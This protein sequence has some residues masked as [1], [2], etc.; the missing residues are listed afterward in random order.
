MLERLEYFKLAPTRILDAGSGPAR[1][2]RPLAARYR[3]EGIVAAD[4][5]LGML[6]SRS[7]GWLRRN[8]ADALCAKLEQLPLAA[9]TFDLVWSNMA[10]HA[11]AEPLEALKEFHRI[12]KPEGLL[13]FSML[14]PDSLKELRA[15]AGAA[16]V[17]AFH[18]M[19]DIGDMLVA[20]GFSAPVMD[21]ELLHFTYPDPSAL[22]DDLRASGQTNVRRDRPRGLAGKRFVRRLREA[23]EPRATFEIVYGHAWK[24]R[25]RAEREETV[26]TIGI[27]KRIP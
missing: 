16:R 4:F 27:F 23:L 7:R 19:H 6:Q 12:L 20:A 11:L 15:V 17:H 25:P 2:A 9:G 10:L 3:G 5:S 13:M 18:D 26:K 14:G 22:L 24:A 21:M 1:E 8:P